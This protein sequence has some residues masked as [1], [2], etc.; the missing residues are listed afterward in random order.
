[1]RDPVPGGVIPLSLD[2]MRHLGPALDG[3]PGGGGGT[4][5]TGGGTW[6]GDL[7][8]N[9]NR[10]HSL[11]P[12]SG[13]KTRRCWYFAP[14]EY[15]SL[16]KHFPGVSARLNIDFFCVEMLLVLLGQLLA[17][18]ETR[19]ACLFLAQRASP[20]TARFLRFNFSARSSSFKGSSIAVPN[21]RRPWRR[22]RNPR[23]RGGRNWGCSGMGLWVTVTFCLWTWFFLTN[24]TTKVAPAPNGHHRPLQ[25]E[26]EDQEDGEGSDIGDGEGSTH[27]ETVAQDLGGGRRIG[28]GY[29]DR[30]DLSQRRWVPAEQF[31][32]G[33]WRSKNQ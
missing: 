32:E 16:R 7:K 29:N 3:A 11:V 24:Y 22:D 23:R 17:W 10:F 19:P 25:A 15:H 2:L 8:M 1:M 13:R 21:G 5:W 27:G 6:L 18:K 20:A 9:Y 28:W 14:L 4:R 12:P 31:A 33:W 30:R 26:A